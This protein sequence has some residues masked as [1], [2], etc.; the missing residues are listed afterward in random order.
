MVARMLTFAFAFAFAFAFRPLL[1][2]R[3]RA[4]QA[5]RR[6]MLQDGKAL[7]T[8]QSPA[9]VA[10]DHSGRAGER[11]ALLAAVELASAARFK[12]A[13]GSSS[14]GRDQRGW[15]WRRWRRWRR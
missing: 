7:A 4:L 6:T 12:S 8:A 2:R 3:G 9:G 14:L 1:T 5:I 15:W 10:V 11:P 13:A